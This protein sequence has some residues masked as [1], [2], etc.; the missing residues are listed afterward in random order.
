MFRKTLQ[1]GEAGDNLGALVRGL[2]REDVRRGQVACAP[3]SQTAHSKFRAKAYV[4]TEAEGGRHTSF[5]NNYRPQFFFRTAD[6]TGSCKLLG[7][8]VALPG[9][10]CEL[11]I[12]LIMPVAMSQGYVVIQHCSVWSATMGLLAWVPLTMC[13][14]VCCVLCVVCCVLCVVVV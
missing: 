5:A 1:R 10:N 3:G 2:K 7:A 9:D 4:L 12:D 6:I 8:P 13:V 11:E 14:V